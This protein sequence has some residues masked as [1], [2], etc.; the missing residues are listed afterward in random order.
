MALALGAAHAAGIVHRD[1]KPANII[2]S[3]DRQ[4]KVLDFG[5]ARISRD[6]T[7]TNLTDAG[8]VIGT[9]AYMSP[10]QVRGGEA[11]F[12]SDIYSLGCVLYEAAAG[13]RPLSPP[14]IP[15]RSTGRAR[16]CR[17]NLAAW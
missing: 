17:P 1:V 10:E 15:R 16:I 2:V 8:H 6:D 3:G 12:R 13:H 9:V 14:P 5:I 11:D 7:V 4:A